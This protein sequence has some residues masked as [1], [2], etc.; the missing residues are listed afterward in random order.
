MTRLLSALIL[1]VWLQGAF[2]GPGLAAPIFSAARSTDLASPPYS[3]AVGDLNNDGMLDAAVV[4]FSYSNTVSVLLGNGD[5]F[6]Q[7]GVDYTTGPSPNCL[8][9][10]DLNND[11]K[12]DLVTTS[13]SSPTVWVLMGNGDG[14]FQTKVDYPTNPNPVSVAIGDLDG[15]G[16]R[17]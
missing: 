14:T 13:G 17:E 10:G 16:K 15:D 12:L 11:G 1:C 2:V 6:F 3:A 4:H 7:T 5:G 8:R 9:I